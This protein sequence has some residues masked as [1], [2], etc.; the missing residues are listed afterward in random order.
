MSDDTQKHYDETFACISAAAKHGAASNDILAAHMWEWGSGSHRKY[1]I[2]IQ[3][4]EINSLLGVMANDEDAVYS[5]FEHGWKSRHQ[6]G[7]PEGAIAL[8]TSSVLSDLPCSLFSQAPSGTGLLLQNPTLVYASAKDCGSYYNGVLTI[9]GE[10]IEPLDNATH[11]QAKKDY[12]TIMDEWK[13]SPAGQHESMNSWLGGNDYEFP[14]DV[15]MRNDVPIRK[16]NELCVNAKLEH[17]KAIVVDGNEYERDGSK[18]H[19]SSSANAQDWTE[20]LSRNSAMASRLAIALDNYNSVC[21]VLT[22]HDVETMPTIVIYQ[23]DAE[24]AEDRLVHFPPTEKN[25]A[26]VA[27]VLRVK[28]SYQHAGGNDASKDVGI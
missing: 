6:Y 23:P 21:D 16:H 17:I 1:D 22:A 12:K 28:H 5:D 20:F 3:K 15:V 11:L 10:S 13:H 27:E 9:N 25:R 2:E 14:I 19:V 4:E 24:K 8:S 7:H 26:M 18:E